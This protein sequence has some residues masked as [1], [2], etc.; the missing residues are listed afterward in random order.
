MFHLIMWN[1]MRKCHLQ[2]VNLN[3]HM[4]F[5][6]SKQGKWV[7]SNHH[8][9]GFFLIPFMSKCTIQESSY[10]WKLSLYEWGKNMVQI[11]ARK[12]KGWNLKWYGLTYWIGYT[13]IMSCCDSHQICQ[14]VIVPHFC[15]GQEE[16]SLILW[17][18]YMW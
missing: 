16:S 9:W 17:Y 15:C 14:N 4:D 2:V 8:I 13:K 11:G 1:M 10:L 7:L 6:F 3:Q 12:I 5:A 18:N